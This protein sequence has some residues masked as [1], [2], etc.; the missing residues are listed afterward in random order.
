MV[1]RIC[2][3]CNLIFDRKSTFD[4]HINKKF[5]CGSKKEH[6]DDLINETNKVLNICENLPKFAEICQ[7]LPKFAKNTKNT[8]KKIFNKK[9]DNINIK[10]INYSDIFKSNL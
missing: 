10:K 7:N 8:K 4:F 3:K 9:N 1:Q 2:L 5:D 6:T